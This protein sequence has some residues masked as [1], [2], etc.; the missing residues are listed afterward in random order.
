MGQATFWFTVQEG[1][2]S[3]Q[4]IDLRDDEMV[5]GEG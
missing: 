3:D 2:A 5:I 1:P 4:K